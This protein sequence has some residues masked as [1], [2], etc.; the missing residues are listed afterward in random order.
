MVPFHI[1]KKC[2]PIPVVVAVVGVSGRRVDCH[3]SCR[4]HSAVAAAGKVSWALRWQIYRGTI[5]TRF[6]LRVWRTGSRIDND[7]SVDGINSDVDSI[8]VGG[9]EPRIDGSGG[10]R[11]SGHSGNT[12]GYPLW[13]TRDLPLA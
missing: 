10:R 7:P 11:I 9:T 8:G 3:R 6:I 12:A 2:S 1:E 13:E 4:R 5:R